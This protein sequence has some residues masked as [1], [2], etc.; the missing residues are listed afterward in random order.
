MGVEQDINIVV[1][2]SNSGVARNGYGL[3]GILSHNAAFVPRSK[4]YQNTAALIADGFA[5]DSPEVRAMTE[6]MAQSPHPPAVAI[7][8]A[9]GSAVIQRYSLDAVAHDTSIYGIVVQGEGFADAAINFTSGVGAVAAQVNSAILTGLNA[10]ASKNY[11][12]TFAP[13]VV[14]DFVFTATNGDEIFHKATHGLKTGDGPLQASNSGGALPTGIVA[15]TDYWVI[16]IDANT[17]Y[18]A[19]SLANALAGTHLLISD[20]GSGTNTFSDTVNTVRPDD[21]ITVTGTDASDWFSI[22]VLDPYLM[23]VKQTHSDFSVAAEL[24]AIKL[25]DNSWYWL[26]TL[27]NSITYVEAVALWVEANGKRYFVDTN[28]SDAT[29]VDVGSSPTDTQFALKGLSYSR[30][31]AVY[32][33]RPAAMFSAGIM[34]MLAPKNPGT[35]NAKWKTVIGA[36]ASVLDPTQR[37]NLT[38]KRANYY[39]EDIPG[40][41]YFREG[42]VPS[43]TFGFV[44]VGESIDWVAD[45]LQK[46]L[47]GKFLSV[48]S[49]G[50]TDEDLNIL[51]A[52]GKGTIARGK[53]D[54]YKIMAPG[55]PDN[56]LDPEPTFTIPRVADIDPSS[57]A[58]REVPDSLLSFRLRGNVNKIKVNMTITF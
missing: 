27:Y 11:T 44:D 54:A 19:T 38:A 28:D 34:G 13:L 35:W 8:R 15:V 20:N 40:R 23:T 51:V 9:S 37:A 41:P 4:L 36:E 39:T 30:T 2:L 31:C 50:F 25:K 6:I 46:A 26:H 58:L 57:R 1:N 24:D 14:A 43:A 17:F 5:V 21:A 7:L 55:D 49:I 22:Q 12:A 33:H 32:H 52:A 18:L 47:V 29:Q 42:T 10:V 45:D 53:S 48:D 56:P 3:I 16:R